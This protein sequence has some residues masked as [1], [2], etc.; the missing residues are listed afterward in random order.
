MAVII[1][2]EEQELGDSILPHKTKKG[3]V[4]PPFSDNLRLLKVSQ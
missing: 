1:R 3:G 4:Q 2:L